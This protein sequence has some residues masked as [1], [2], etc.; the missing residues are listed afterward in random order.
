MHVCVR[1]KEGVSASVCEAGDERVV[2]IIS[3]LPYLAAS[4]SPHHTRATAAH[5]M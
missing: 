2:S 3:T 1:I 4:L 5:R